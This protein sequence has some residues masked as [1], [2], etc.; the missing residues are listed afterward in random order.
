[1]DFRKLM[2]LFFGIV[3]IIFLYSIIYYAL[4]IMYRDV[5]GGGK[6]RKGTVQKA[7]GLEVLSSMNENQLRVGSVIPVTSTVTLGRKDDNS[8]IIN[9]DH[10]VSSYHAKIYVRNNEFYLE[11]LA[12]TNGTYVNEEKISGR[13][14]LRIN[15]TV[16]LGSTV[17][18]VIG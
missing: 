12:S 17:F 2:S 8:L 13:I 6:K 11:D 7:H 9:N 1:M 15:D 10:F 3:F 18:K 14:R 16:R 5:K 4:K